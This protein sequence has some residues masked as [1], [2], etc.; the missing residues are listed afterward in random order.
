TGPRCDSANLRKAASRCP[1]QVCRYT[2]PFHRNRRSLLNDPPE[3]QQGLQSIQEGDRLGL[4]GPNG[5]GKST[6]LQIFAG[7]IPPDTGEV[8]VRNGARLVYVPQDS[9]F[10]PTETP[11]SVMQ[12]ALRLASVPEPEWPG[13]EAEAL[14]R[15]GFRDF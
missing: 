3:Q 11:R 2:L 14:G 4:I 15:A 6:L 7:H 1:A 8:V 10:E 13:R 5:S 9:E 12:Q